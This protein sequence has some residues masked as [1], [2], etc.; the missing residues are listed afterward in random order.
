MG[1]TES[2]SMIRASHSGSW[3]PQGQRLQSILASSFSQATVNSSAPGRVR[4]IV[5]PHAGYTYCLQ[6]SA[7]AFKA[8]DPSLFTRVVVLGPSHRLY[9]S[10]CAIPDG[11]SYE[12]PL[13]AIPLDTATCA[14]LAT[15][16]PK[17]FKRLDR[18][19]SEQEHS[20]EMELPILKYI[21]DTKPFSI[22]PIIVG[23]INPSVIQKVAEALTPILRNPETLLVI[24]SDFCH[25]G[26]D[27]DY[28]YLPNVPG[29]INEK[30]EALDREGMAKIA[31]GDVQ[32]F[33]EFIKKTGDTICGEVPIRIGMIGI[34]GPYSV[35]WPHYSQ[36]SPGVRSQRESCVSYAAG[37]F[38]AI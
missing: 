11:E 3:Y 18:R 36:S 14:A 34:G 4:A 23:S 28:V 8:V 27:F 20:I 25:W 5:A 15:Q 9:L 35:E 17:L 33:A 29:S 16:H 31:S 10:Q 22:V 30:I 26:S 2:G 24:S 21:F 6:T 12:T 13:G 37:I 7:Y 32:Q 1:G 38:R 19:T